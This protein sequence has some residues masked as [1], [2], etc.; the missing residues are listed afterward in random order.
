MA[1]GGK[2]KALVTGGAGFI[3]S[4]LADALLD[5]GYRVRALD[6]LSPQVHG[7]GGDRPAYLHP[8]VE[9]VAGDVRDAAAVRRALR[10]VDA[11]YHFAACVG[12]GQSMYEVARYTDVN[13]LGTAVL[14][15][16]LVERPVE[17]L[18]VASSMS[19]YG[20]GLYAD[21]AGRV[22]AGSDRTLEQLRRGDW[23]VRGPDGEELAPLPAVLEHRRA[24]L[25]EQS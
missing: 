6:S 25:V 3:G 12:V 23:E 16:A 21:A 13:N 22:T 1:S 19:L 11:V 17:R 4:H 2:R 7:D 20:E 5:R 8:E 15:E 14:L 18:V 9:L 24:F 10:G